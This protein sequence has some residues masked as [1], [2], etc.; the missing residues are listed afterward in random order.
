MRNL[1]K[2]KD[3]Y[4]SDVGSNT[5]EHFQVIE[6]LAPYFCQSSIAEINHDMS[7]QINEA[8]NKSMTA[9]AS[10][11]RAYNSSESLEGRQAVVFLKKIMVQGIILHIF[12]KK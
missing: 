7:T 4:Y 9:M 11:D 2:S 6:T 3:K 1:L 12:V 8:L 5:L 10:K